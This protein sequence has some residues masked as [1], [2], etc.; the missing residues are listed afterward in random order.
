MD[1]LL[2]NSNTKCESISKCHQFLFDKEFNRIIENPFWNQEEFPIPCVQT[3]VIRFIT[4]YVSPIY[5]STMTLAQAVNAANSEAI[6]ED[7]KAKYSF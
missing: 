6:E 4:H 1:S 5:L 3:D 7:D 2:I